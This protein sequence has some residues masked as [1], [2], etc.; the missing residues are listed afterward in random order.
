MRKL[1][2]NPATA[3]PGD[4]T[5]GVDGPGPRLGCCAA[6]PDRDRVKARILAMMSGFMAVAPAGPRAAVGPGGGLRAASRVPL[7]VEEADM[8]DMEGGTA[9][10]ETVRGGDARRFRAGLGGGDASSSGDVGGEGEFSGL[11]S[12]SAESD[13]MVVVVVVVVLAGTAA[14]SGEGP[15]P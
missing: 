5:P 8:L 11:S 12:S 9:L 3:G 4:D 15:R 7:G 2:G 14:L 6:G 1:E 13:M 10:S